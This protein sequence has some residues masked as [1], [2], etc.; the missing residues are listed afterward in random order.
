[1]SVVN[2]TYDVDIATRFHKN[3]GTLKS[4]ENI[5]SKFNFF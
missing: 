3:R 4:S 5:L 1:M 2:G